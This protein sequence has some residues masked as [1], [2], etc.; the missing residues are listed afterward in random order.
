MPYANFTSNFQI[1]YNVANEM[2][3][4]QSNQRAAL[5]VDSQL[6]GVTALVGEYGILQEG[7]YNGIYSSGNSSVSLIATGT[8]Y[9][10]QGTINGVYIQQNTTL[11]W[12]GIPDNTKVYLYLIT[13]ES[14]L[15]T[16]GQFSSLAYRQCKTSYNTTGISPVNGILVGTATTT[17]STITLNTSGTASDNGTFSSGKPYVVPYT[18]IAISTLQNTLTNAALKTN[19]S[20]L[21]STLQVV[22]T[23]ETADALAIG[24]LVS[25]VSGLTNT[26]QVVQT[27]ETADALA[28]GTLTSNSS[29]LTSTIDTVQAKETLDAANIAVLK[30]NFSGIGNTMGTI[31]TNGISYLTNRRPISDVNWS[32][33]TSDYCFAF[34]ALTAPRTLWLPSPNSA[35]AN[36]IYL[37]VDESGHAG[38]HPISVV[39]TVGLINGSGVSSIVTNFGT[40]RT[41]HN[42]S[43]YFII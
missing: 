35:T 39:P 15:Y 24:T 1:P 31:Q 40:L 37:V 30:S 25:S 9:A 17:T 8:K 29:G 14:N 22:Q 28:I 27:G 12:T 5:I 19:F 42:G 3:S 11:T 7:N 36:K 23:G 32:G 6:T 33:T 38:S 18:Q 2:S 26:I 41:Y 16:T 4:G 43:N 13:N 10:I 20:G 21:A 34:T